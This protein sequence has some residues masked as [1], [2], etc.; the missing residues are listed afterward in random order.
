MS[1]SP[2]APDDFPCGQTYVCVVSPCFDSN[3]VPTT[4][5]SYIAI[6][7]S[8]LSAFAEDLPPAHL[9]VLFFMLGPS[10]SLRSPSR[11]MQ[12]DEGACFRASCRSVMAS[13]WLGLI[14]T[15]GLNV[16]IYTRSPAS[17]FTSKMTHDV[18]PWLTL[19]YQLPNTCKHLFHSFG[20]THDVGGPHNT[21]HS[22][23]MTSSNFHP[24]A[25]LHPKWHM[26]CGHG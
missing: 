5:R 18:W 7:S 15:R 8:I 13:S 22:Q 17:G 3:L 14:Q 26:M 25:D 24:L 20:S 21:A 6:R 10:C 11:T 9:P 16:K 2:C 1:K 19:N 4:N 23:C 12:S